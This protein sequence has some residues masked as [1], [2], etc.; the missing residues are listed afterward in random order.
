MP[1]AARIIAD[2]IAPSGHRLTT[3][4]ATY[5]RCIHSEIMTHRVYARNAASSRA[6]PTE[7]LIQRVVDDPFIPIEWG[8][9]QKGM[10][11]GEE[12]SHADKTL[13]LMEWL[14]GRDDAVRTAKRLLELGLH[15][16][17]VNRVIEPWIHITIILSGT[18]WTNFFGLRDH[19]DAEPHFQVLAK[20]MRDV[21]EASRPKELRDGEWHTPLLDM[22]AADTLA[23]QQA[24]TLECE[25]LPEPGASFAEVHERLRAKVSVGR[26]ARVS[27]LTHDGKRDIQADIDLHDRL[28]DANPGHWSP[29]EH[30]ARAGSDPHLRSGC[31]QGF[32]QYRKLFEQEHIGGRM[33]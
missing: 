15:K 26:C 14:N 18:T 31:F 21:Y 9:N 25:Q 5:P 23:L 3:F 1:I 16:Q 8:K 30:V 4:E 2:S 19:R 17:I 13:A 10:Q 11:A 32:A 28:K 27:Y 6:I 12:L 29:F 33:P 7:K 20:T 22:D 24:A